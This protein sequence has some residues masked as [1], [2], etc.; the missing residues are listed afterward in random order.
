MTSGG[1]G[2]G[3]GM[4][5]EMGISGGGDIGEVAFMEENGNLPSANSTWRE[6]YIRLEDM[7]RH[8]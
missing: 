4:I 1:M 7:S 8:R 2:G 5:S 6:M 3:V